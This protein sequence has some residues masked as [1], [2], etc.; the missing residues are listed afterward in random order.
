MYN[1]SAII[2]ISNP[3]AATILETKANHT[4]LKKTSYTYSVY[5]LTK[6]MHM[7]QRKKLDHITSYTVK[8]RNYC[9]K[10]FLLFDDM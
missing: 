7:Q 6:Y 5:F 9:T 10:S 8:L 1:T 2:V 4:S 3:T